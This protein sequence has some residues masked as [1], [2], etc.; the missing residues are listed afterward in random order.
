MS[1][2]G[3]VANA[4]Q[5]HRSDKYSALEAS[6]LTLEDKAKSA[7]IL[8]NLADARN[9]DEM[10][11][12]QLLQLKTTKF[13]TWVPL[14]TPICT[15]IGT[16]ITVVVQNKQLNTTLREQRQQSESVATLQRDASEDAQW[17]EALKSVSFVLGA[18]AMQGFFRSPRYG[19]QARAIASALL[20]DIP[21]VNAFDEVLSRIRDNTTGTNFT[22][23]RVVAQM[24][25]FAQ[26]ARFHMKGA[27]EN[28]DGLNFTRANLNFAILYNASSKGANFN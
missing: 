17:R 16:T 8:K 23:L 20:T 5:A 7:E 14:L 3:P 9:S 25:G 12:I 15:L 27:A 1:D 18:F 24:L 2:G 19:S 6:A 21:N 4:A 13:A 28:F 10:L 26:R 22:D 11:R